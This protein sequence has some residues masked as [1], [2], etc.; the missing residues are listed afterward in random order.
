MIQLSATSKQRLQS[1][2][3]DLVKVVEKCAMLSDL[4]FM[5]T[6]GIRSKASQE[7]AV[8]AGFSTTMHSRHLPGP[9]D[10]KAHAVDLAPLV[11][12]KIPW[13]IS[14]AKQKAHWF[15]LAAFM[16][17]AAKFHSVPVEWGGDW[18]RFKDYPHFQ[19]PWDKFPG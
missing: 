18:K 3:P 5:V 6:C 1:V 16:K 9:H 10:G 7:K 13:S 17:E 11:E 12:G 19:L 8:I 15:K 4:Q 14:N 2:H